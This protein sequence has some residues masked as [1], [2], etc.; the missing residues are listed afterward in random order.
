MIVGAK[1]RVFFAGD[2]GYWS[3]LKEV[4]QRFAPIDLA[5]L[6]IGGYSAWDKGH[7]NHLNPEEAVKL[8]EELG[9]KLM[10]P[11]HWGTFELNREPFNEPPDRLFAEAVRRGVEERVAPLSPGE[12]I[13][14]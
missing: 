2:T 1:K 8:F 13:D 14:W 7:P 9:A 4:G 10:I 12:T 5:L 3:G 11:M 6:P